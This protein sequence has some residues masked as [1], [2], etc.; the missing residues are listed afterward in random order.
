MLSKALDKSSA[1]AHEAPDLLK[2]LAILSDK[3]IRRY[4]VGKRVG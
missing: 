2:T 4:A 3:T 1:T